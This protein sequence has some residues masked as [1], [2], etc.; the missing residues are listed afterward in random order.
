MVTAFGELPVGISCTFLAASALLIN[1]V[2]LAIASDLPT[3]LPDLEMLLPN[4]T[5]QHHVPRS[6]P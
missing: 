6:T 1:C 2:A 5:V 4:D 3:V